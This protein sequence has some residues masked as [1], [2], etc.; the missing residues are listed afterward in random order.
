VRAEAARVGMKVRVGEEH[1]ILERR[2][3]VG[4]VVG[5]YG[6]E[7]YV[8]VDVRFP[9][10]HHRLFWPGDLEE[11][12]SA[13]ESQVRLLPR[14]VGPRHSDPASPGWLVRG[15]FSAR[16][17]TKECIVE[18]AKENYRELIWVHARLLGYVTVGYPALLS[19]LFT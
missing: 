3:M 13:Q 14:R 5:R 6:G 17:A 1:R 15:H 4:K 19:P 10:G 12:A 18:A 7:V 11:I 2:G 16:G 8:V 9:E